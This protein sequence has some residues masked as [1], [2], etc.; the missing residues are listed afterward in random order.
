MKMLNDYSKE[1]CFGKRPLPLPDFYKQS[2]APTDE[3]LL[4]MEKD[5]E[6]SAARTESAMGT[7]NDRDEISKP[8]LKSNV[9]K[10]SDSLL[11]N[12]SNPPFVTSLKGAESPKPE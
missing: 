8:N 1:D 10:N 11:K 3:E 9:R 2:F 5:D 12:M 7:P 4:P 6:K